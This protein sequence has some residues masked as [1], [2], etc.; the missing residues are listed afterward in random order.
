MAGLRKKYITKPERIYADPLHPSTSDYDVVIPQTTSDA[1]MVEGTNS[2]LTDYLSDVGGIKADQRNTIIAG[3][4]I[5]QVSGNNITVGNYAITV[6][7]GF[8][9]HGSQQDTIFYSDTYTSVATP[10]ASD[11]YLVMLNNGTFT[12]VP[13]FDGGRDF[14]TEN[15]ITNQVFFHEQLR[16]SYKFNGSTWDAYPCTAIA[17]FE[18]GELAEILPYNTWWWD[19]VVWENHEVDL[20]AGMQ[21]SAYEDNNGDFFLRVRKGGVIDNGHVFTLEN[22]MYKKV[23]LPFTAGQEGGSGDGNY[24]N[25]MTDIVP[26]SITPSNLQGF[27]IGGNNSSEVFNAL[28]PDYAPSYPRWQSSGIPSYFTIGFP[29]AK[30]I[31]K[32]MVTSF[33]DAARLGRVANSWTLL[34][35]NNGGTTWEVVDNVTSAGFSALNETKSFYPTNTK[36]YG[37]I[38][39]VVTSTLN[40]SDGFVSVGQIRFY[41]SVPELNVFVITDDAGTTDVLT[42]PYSGPTLP[43]GYT[44]YHRIGKISIGET[45]NLFGAFPTTPIGIDVAGKY[46]SV[47]E[48]VNTK[49]NSSLNNLPSSALEFAANLS[50]PRIDTLNSTTISGGVVYKAEKSGYAII[51]NQSNTTLVYNSADRNAV[52]N[53]STD[54][55]VAGAPA[56]IPCSVFVAKDSYYKV[57]S[58]GALSIKFVPTVGASL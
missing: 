10:T 44:Y 5:V 24:T 37:M 34:G 42:S 45:A 16:R 40:D 32:Y 52:A 14:P 7:N 53:D 17:R 30:S 13:S 25:I 51:Y 50:A 56:G 36:K 29:E 20:P 33:G 4:D 6:A 46:E 2:N 1:V 22:D 27:S 35:S 28:N 19:E 12:Y 55:L 23:Q 3:S 43:L 11:R 21:V 41:S 26:T 9:E 18:N 38:K 58:T 49:A 8:N 57:D 47:M 39:F 54:A 31:N 15:L 48:E